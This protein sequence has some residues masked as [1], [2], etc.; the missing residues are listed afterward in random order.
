MFGNVRRDFEQRAAS[1]VLDRAAS[2]VFTQNLQFNRGLQRTRLKNR[3]DGILPSSTPVSREQAERNAA[4]SAERALQAK[5]KANNKKKRPRKR[6]HAQDEEEDILVEVE[7]EAEDEVAET[8]AET[9]TPSTHS[10]SAPNADADVDADVDPDEEVIADLRKQVAERRAD[11]RHQQQKAAHIEQQLVAM[12][13]RA[14]GMV[15]RIELHDKAQLHDDIDLLEG[16]LRYIREDMP[17]QEAH[18]A[19]LMA[20]LEAIW[21]AEAATAKLL[22]ARRSKR[23]R[24]HAAVH[25]GT[26]NTV[27]DDGRMRGAD[28]R[29]LLAWTV[30]HKLRARDSGI[31]LVNSTLCMHCRRPML[32][33]PEGQCFCKHC[34]VLYDADTMVTAEMLR[35]GKRG[36]GRGS[37]HY[38]S[39]KHFM[40]RVRGVQGQRH[41]FIHHDIYRDL[42]AYW[43]KY[44]IPK[45]ELDVR[46]CREALNAIDQAGLYEYVQQILT[47]VT[48]VRPPQIP[49]VMLNELNICIRMI[50][51]V[52]PEFQRIKDDEKAR[53]DKLAGKKPKYPTRN[54]PNTG[55]CLN[56]FFTLLGHPYMC[57][58]NW[59]IWE[60]DN[61]RDKD[62][63]MERCFEVYNWEFTPTP[64][65]S[66]VINSAK[67]AV[68][69]RR[70]EA[71][72]KEKEAKE[73]EEGEEGGAIPGAKRGRRSRVK[74]REG[75]VA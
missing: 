36:G 14:S 75:Q 43:H 64:E 57:K 40:T 53:Q 22:G 4:R 33:T 60:R 47:V 5:D 69:R 29:K 35:D 50:H 12:R 10:T 39:S 28:F 18:F 67:A 26:G 15:T 9:E 58:Y 55:Y 73:G 17:R 74:A 13:A 71:E 24:W 49:P 1:R 11:M 48:G 3:T 20:R 63:I 51:R 46:T 42:C 23:K 25:G 38:V 30:S 37:G 2:Q 72:A 54:K 66:M 65:S 56:Q 68:K 32:L 41:T 21:R 6:K 45:E 31:L 61:V 62:E 59:A 7:D 8:R 34:K 70:K 52:W 19:N 27:R 16:R 44:G